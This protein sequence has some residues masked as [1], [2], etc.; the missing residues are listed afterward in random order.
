VAWTNLF[1]RALL[2]EREEK[3]R[4]IPKVSLPWDMLFAGSN[5]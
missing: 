3:R 2:D 4:Q 5:L 1:V